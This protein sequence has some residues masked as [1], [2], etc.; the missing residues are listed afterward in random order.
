MRLWP[1]QPF[2]LGATYDGA[3]TN[4]SLFSE[5]ATGVD[6][7]LFDDDGARGVHPSHRGDRALLARLPAQRRSRPALRL[8]GPRPLRAATTGTAATRRSCCSTPTPRRSRARST[9]TRPSS[10]TRSAATTWSPTSAT[11]PPFVPKAVVTNPF[12][13]WGVDRPPCIPL[14]RDGDLRGPRQGLHQAASRRRRRA[15]RHLRRP[16][17]P[18]GHRAPHEPRGDRRRADARPP[19]RPRPLPGR[20]EA[21]GT[22]GATTPS[23]SSP[24][25]T[26]T[27]PAGS[28]ASR[29]A[30]SRPWCG[31]CTRPASR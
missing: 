15:A 8:P 25:T 30:S 29:S 17:P 13:D 5:V 19:V 20:E 3:G 6:L 27:P 7:C 1:G 28:A 4:F 23:A 31:R 16:G 10:A 21:C 2:P 12:F 18:G 24:P 22:T 26:T 9:G 11:A 14:A